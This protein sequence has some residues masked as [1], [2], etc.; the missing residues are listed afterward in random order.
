[1]LIVINIQIYSTKNDYK[2]KEGKIMTYAGKLSQEDLIKYIQPAYEHYHDVDNFDINPAKVILVT[3]IVKYC[4]TFKFPRPPSHI[5]Y[6][7]MSICGRYGISMQPGNNKSIKYMFYV[8][9][10]DVYVGEV[11]GIVTDLVPEDISFEEHLNT[12]NREDSTSYVSTIIFGHP[13]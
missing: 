13:R 11:K 1:M 12:Y 3:F 9:T 7:R 4:R 8:K 6:Y 5:D 2:N 10:G